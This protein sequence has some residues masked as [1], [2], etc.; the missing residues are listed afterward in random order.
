MTRTV[1]KEYIKSLEDLYDA[2]R[3]GMEMNTVMAASDAVTAAKIKMGG[4]K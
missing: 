4:K 2:V 3:M 1:S